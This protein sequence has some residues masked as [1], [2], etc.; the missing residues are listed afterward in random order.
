MEPENNIIK[1]DIFV[2]NSIV[3][4]FANDG[5]AVLTNL[6]FPKNIGG[7]VNFNFVK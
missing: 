2:D 6:V 5:K 1:L 4:I 7:S 3:E